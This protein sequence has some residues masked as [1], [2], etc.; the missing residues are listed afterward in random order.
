[1]GD[2]YTIDIACANCGHINKLPCKEHNAFVIPDE[3]DKMNDKDVVDY[4]AR[5]GWQEQEELLAKVNK[6]LAR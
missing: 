2:R 1:M 4:F 6:V 3:S 5:L